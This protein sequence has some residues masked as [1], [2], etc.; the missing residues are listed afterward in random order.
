MK[1]MLKAAVLLSAFVSANTFACTSFLL[2]GGDRIYFARNLDWEWRDGL[3]IVNPSGMKKMSFVMPGNTPAKWTSKHGSV[4]FNQFGREMPFGG[5]NEAGL[6]VENMWLGE[7]GFPETD[8]RPAIN[9]LQWI[10]YQLDNCSTVAEVLATDKEIRLE[11]PPVSAA[12]L[13]RIHYLVADASGDVATVEFLGGKMVV[14]RG[15]DLPMR[16]L[17]NDP[18]EQAVAYARKHPKQ[19]GAGERLKDESSMARFACA[20]TRSADFKPGTAEEDLKYA[21]DG[22]DQVAQGNF[23]VWRIVYDLPG[24]AIHFRI[25]KNAPDQVVNLKKLDFSCSRTVQFAKIEAHPSTNS[26]AFSALTE[27]VHR[28]Y[29][30]SFLTK[31]DVKREMGDLRPIMEGQLFVLRGFTCGD[32]AVK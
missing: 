1:Q 14:H 32:E 24:R 27:P 3:V 12:S 18:Y 9:L 7:T 4:T 20:A 13:A 25:A 29:L 16:A 10:Q 6:V 30:S 22:L 31:A 23:T 19:P 8:S 21:F 17:A 26:F 5:M 11:P 2:Q 28:D 15:P